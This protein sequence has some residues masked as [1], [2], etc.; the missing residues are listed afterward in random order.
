MKKIILILGMVCLSSMIMKS[1]EISFEKDKIDYGVIEYN[2]DGFK[3]FIFKNTGKEP[4]IITNVQGQCGCTTTIE[5]G[6]PGWPQEPI[7][8]NHSGIIKIKYD[9][10]RIGKFE[11]VITIYSN[12]IKGN[13]IIFI[14]GEVKQK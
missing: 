2:S 9:T 1:Q 12:S 10:K 13:K 8:P 14:S 11:K 6:I 4:L 7:N 5:N 3:E